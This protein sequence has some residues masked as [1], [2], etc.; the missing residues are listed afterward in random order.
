MVRTACGK[1]GQAF[2]DGLAGR[3]LDAYLLR[4]AV[5]NF[6]DPLGPNFIATADS[7]GASVCDGLCTRRY[8]VPNQFSKVCPVFI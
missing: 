8:G 2:A 3:G 4:M 7:L 6:T 5:V 1:K